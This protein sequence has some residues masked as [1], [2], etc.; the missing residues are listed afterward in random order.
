MPPRTYWVYKALIAIIIVNALTTAY[1]FNVVKTQ[2]RE[3][4]TLQRH[5]T[6]QQSVDKLNTKYESLKSRIEGLFH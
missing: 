5:D 6:V 3:I 2:Q 1:L 4:Q